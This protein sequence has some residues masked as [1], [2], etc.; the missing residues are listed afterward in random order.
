MNDWKPLPPRS[1][2]GA[3]A[4]WFTQ[5]ADHVFLKEVAN[6]S[7]QV[8]TPSELRGQKLGCTMIL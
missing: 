8:K 2:V 3:V 6:T 7:S 1:P 5:L 4:C